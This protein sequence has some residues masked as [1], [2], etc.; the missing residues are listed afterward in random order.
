[1]KQRERHVHLQRKTLVA[2]DR[3]DGILTRHGLV[4]KWENFGFQL[5]DNR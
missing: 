5:K 1:M 3:L 4:A 2:A